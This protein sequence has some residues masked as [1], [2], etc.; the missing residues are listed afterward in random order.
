M[1]AFA[2]IDILPVCHV[3]KG[4][5]KTICG[6]NFASSCHLKLKCTSEKHGKLPG[7]INE[8]NLQCEVYQTVIESTL[9]PG[10]GVEEA[11][12]PEPGNSAT[13]RLSHRQV[14]SGPRKGPCSLHFS[15]FLAPP[16]AY[17]LLAWYQTD[18]RSRPE[19]SSV[20]GKD[21]PIRSESPG[22][23]RY[24]KPWFRIRQLSSGV[25]QR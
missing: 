24:Q 4:N 14:A 15:A 18:L 7:T 25:G 21:V 9:W 11:T 20:C 22:E 17:W 1:I 10:W 3:D 12:V 6:W 2:H 5:C 19:S 23:L 16:L 13:M 8:N